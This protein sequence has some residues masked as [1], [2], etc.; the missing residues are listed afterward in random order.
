MTTALP[1]AVKVWMGA[2]VIQIEF[3][4]GQYR[5]MRTHFINDYL[6]AWSPKKGK[7]KRKNLWLPP[8]WEWLGSNA[9]IQPDGTVILFDKDVYTAKELWENSCDSI[10]LVS[11]V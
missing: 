1:K 10:D 2:N 6:L 4:N 3:D 9:Q 7:G 11:G 5:Y 8:T